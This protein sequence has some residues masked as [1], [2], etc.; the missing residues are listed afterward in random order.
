MEG[1]NRLDWVKK[2]YPDFKEA[3]WMNDDI[4]I[5]YKKS[6]TLTHNKTKTTWGNPKIGRGNRPTVWG[7]TKSW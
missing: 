7:D 2:I 3:K 6:L 1:L 5:L 4:Y